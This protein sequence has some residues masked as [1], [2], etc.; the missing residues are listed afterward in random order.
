M[1]YYKNEEIDHVM[2]QQ[3]TLPRYAG[4]ARKVFHYY[5]GDLYN[6]ETMGCDIEFKFRFYIQGF[7]E[8]KV[9][10]KEP[11]DWPVIDNFFKLVLYHEGYTFLNYDQSILD[12]GYNGIAHGEQPK[13]WA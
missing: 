1:L 9:I 11:Y 3:R 2:R 4:L 10:N 5:L 8:R 6:P 13:H 7:V 12:K